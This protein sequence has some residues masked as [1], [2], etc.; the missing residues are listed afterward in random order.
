[1]SKRRTRRPILRF[2]T[3]PSS[4]STADPCEPA[5]EKGTARSRFYREEWALLC[6]A[7]LI[8]VLPGLLSGRRAVTPELESTIMEPLSIDVENAPWYEW[9]LLHGIGEVRA[10][11]IVEYVEAHRPLAN[12]DALRD[13]PGLP[14]GWLEKARVH[15]RLGNRSRNRNRN[16]NRNREKTSLPLFPAS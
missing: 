1:M 6:V 12:L 3:R 9:A 11:R 10:K 15:L 5:V 14:A 2:W 7:V 16:R 4:I 13:V 8:A